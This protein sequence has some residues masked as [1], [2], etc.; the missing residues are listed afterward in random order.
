LNITIK[1]LKW[2]AAVLVALLAIYVLTIMLFV[3][4]YL[5]ASP[6]Y[7]EIAIG[8]TLAEIEGR[9]GLLC[10][11]IEDRSF[12]EGY[13]L[14]SPFDELVQNSENKIVSYSIGLAFFTVIYDKQGNFLAKIDNGLDG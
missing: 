10:S 11:S 2:S 3:I 4:G 8:D 13:Q 7:E 6:I 14:M 5:Y 1:L 12:I 9:K